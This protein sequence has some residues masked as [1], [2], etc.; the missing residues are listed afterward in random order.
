MMILFTPGLD[1]LE[2]SMALAEGCKCG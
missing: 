2:I 1:I